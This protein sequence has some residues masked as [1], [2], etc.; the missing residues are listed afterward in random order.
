M[1]GTLQAILMLAVAGVA[2]AQVHKVWVDDNGEQN[3]DV[4][5]ALRAKIGGTTRYSLA[6]EAYQ[7]EIDVIVVCVV[8]RGYA[9]SYAFTFW[10]PKTSPMQL[11]GQTGL[12]TGAT[13]QETAELIFE[14][15]VTETTDDK[16]TAA[17]LDQLNV[18]W[19]FCKDPAHKPYCAPL[20]AGK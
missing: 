11:K 10:S 7:T 20:P 9:C 12:A 13:A 14:T 4:A 15:F 2:K 3:K 19:L 1:R 16:I 8:N 18:I 5:N 6:S 17:I